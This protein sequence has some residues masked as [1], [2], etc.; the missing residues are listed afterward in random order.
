[1]LGVGCGYLLGKCIDAI[2]E[3]MR[4]SLGGLYGFYGYKYGIELGS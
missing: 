3:Y 1:M 2:C 4:V